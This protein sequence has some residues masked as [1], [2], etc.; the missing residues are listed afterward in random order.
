M[1]LYNASLESV[2]P[3]DSVDYPLTF[4]EDGEAL[5]DQLS[6]VGINDETAEQT[7]MPF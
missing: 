2:K 1:A 6:R 5:A 4:R 3:I 7:G